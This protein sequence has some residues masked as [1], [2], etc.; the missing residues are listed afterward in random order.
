[1]SK[2]AIIPG[3]LTRFDQYAT[4]GGSMST[5]EFGRRMDHD[6][7]SMLKRSTEI[8][9]G[10]GAI[11][12]KWYT[13]FVGDIGHGSYVQ[14]V[15]TWIADG[16]TVEHTCTRRDGTPIIFGIG[17]IHKNGIDAPGT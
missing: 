5:D 12:D 4:D 2:F 15:T 10:K 11:H 3:K 1:M 9:C 6:I 8:G 7:S 16:F 17:A 14:H 13:S